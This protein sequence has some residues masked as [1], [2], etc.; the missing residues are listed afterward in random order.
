M[1]IGAP[2]FEETAFPTSH[3][4]M[5][6]GVSAPPDGWGNCAIYMGVIVAAGKTTPAPQTEAACII[7]RNF[8]PAS[9]DGRV[10]DAKTRGLTYVDLSIKQNT[11]A[12][13]LLSLRKS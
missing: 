8:A 1:A 6:F 5:N 9:A 11:I 7:N 10:A 12:Y 4:G 2:A 3:E 13:C